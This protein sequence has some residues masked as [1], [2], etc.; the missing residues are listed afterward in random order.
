MPDT[1]FRLRIA[2]YNL[3]G[4]KDDAATAAAVVRAIAPDVLLLQELPRYPGSD[5]AISSFARE[6]RMLWS[7]RT[8]WVSGTG[9]LTGLRPLPTDSQDV[10]LPVGL[11]ENPRSY[12]VTQVRSPHGPAITVASVHLPLREQQRAEHTRTLLAG[13]AAEGG[14]QAPL[15]VGGDLNEG[16]S[17]AAWGVLATGLAVV[18]DDRPTYPARKPQHRIDA[19]FSR[20]HVLAIPGDPQLLQ[21]M[22]LER[23][24]D[25]LPVW[26]DLTF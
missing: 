17:G 7:G 3:R 1:G 9:M 23:A 8:R 25:H 5:Y 18:S 16:P 12:T 26:V 4:L 2:S 22:P 11:R 6:A 10:K 20:G 14:A 13:L 24:T 19:I 15:V 21:G